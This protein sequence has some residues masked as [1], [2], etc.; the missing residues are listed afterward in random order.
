MLVLGKG[1]GHNKMAMIG[2]NATL[3]LLSFTLVITNA[4]QIGLIHQYAANYDEEVSSFD[5]CYF[6]VAFETFR[7]PN[8]M[9]RSHV[10]LLSLPSN[11]LETL[12]SSSSP[13]LP[14]SSFL[15]LI[16]SS[17]LLVECLDAIVPDLET[18]SCQ[19][20]Q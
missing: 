6:P 1:K 12:Q 13:Q 8:G 11:W 5:G 14:F 19:L 20:S 10:R 17:N 15:T 2:V 9:V 4:C 3:L 16:R 7:P 18:L